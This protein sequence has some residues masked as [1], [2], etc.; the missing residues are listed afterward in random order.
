MTAPS[1]FQHAAVLPLPRWVLGPGSISSLP[2][3][4]ALLRIAR[5]LLLSDVGLERAGVLT[6][7]A[8]FLPA[9]SARYLLASEDP[10]CLD[11]DQAFAIYREAGCDGIVAVGGGSVIDTAKILAALT[12]APT[13]GA[14]GLLGRPELIGPGVALL[15]AVPT[16]IG[17][18]SESSP[19]TGLH[20]DENTR[21]IGTRSPFLVPRSVVSDPM[22]VRSLPQRLIAATG[23]DALAHCLEGYL[24]DPPHPLVDAIALDGLARAYRNV[25]AALRRESDDARQELMVASFA[26]GVAIHKGLG[27][28]HAVAL[29]CGDQ[30]LHHGMLVAAAL[31]WAMEIAA[32]KV[33]AKSDRMAQALQLNSRF[34]LAP[35]LRAL[36]VSLGLPSHL[37]RAGYRVSD[38]DELVQAMA[39][40]PFNR[41]AAYAPTIGEYRAM[42]DT[43]LF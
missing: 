40:S 15:L 5:P 6:T 38:P 10:T 9:S 34:D 29:A 13:A 33:P 2:S 21:A 20:P 24:A 35:A 43:L 4:L 8:A 17:T 12:Q 11:A 28:A 14:R 32:A 22:L 16:T 42:A 31:P 25:Y 19:A 39:S 41:S 30:R 18:G 26:G 23:M 37:G 36:N 3:E 7:V 1:P 27:P